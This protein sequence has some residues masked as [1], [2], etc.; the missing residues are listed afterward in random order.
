M[1]GLLKFS[2]QFNENSYQAAEFSDWL[3]FNYQVT[4][5]SDRSLK[6]E[7]KMYARFI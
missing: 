6:I 1:N 3:L 5:L 4:K 7:L 2:D